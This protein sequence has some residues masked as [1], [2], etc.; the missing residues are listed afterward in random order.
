[1]I[2]DLL[3]EGGSGGHMIHPFN[4]PSVN[5]G[6]DLIEFFEK[7]AQFV[8]RKPKEGE[9]IRASKSSSIKFDGVNASIKLIDGPGGK[10]FALDRGSLG[11]LDISGVTA[12]KLTQR[13]AEGH[14]MIKVGKI[15]LDIFNRALPSIEN[16]LKQLGVYDDSTKFLNAEFVWKKTN[17]VQYPED[18]IAIHGVNQYYEKTHSRN[19]NYRPGLTRPTGDDGKPVKLTSTEVDYDEDALESLKEKTKPIAERYG[20]NLYTVVPTFARGDLGEIDFGPALSTDVTIRFE[21]KA[22]TKPLQDWLSQA[23]NPRNK[24]V[25][26]SDGRKTTALSKFVYQ[27]LLGGASLAE[28]LVDPDD[29]QLAIDGAILYFATQLLGS[30][31]LN[32]L[33]SPLGDLTGTETNHEGIVLRDSELFGPRP[34]KI[35]GE[36]ISSG[37]DSPFRKKEPEQVSTINEEEQEFEDT[38]EGGDEEVEPLAKDN[39]NVM[40]TVAVFPGKFKPPQEGHME[41]VRR[42]LDKVDYVYVMISPLPRKV[43]DKDIG[44]L[45]SKKVWDLYIENENLEGKVFAIKSPFNS[46]VQASYAVMDGE[47]PEFVPRKGD[48]I[49]PVASDKLDAPTRNRPGRPDYLRFAKYHE[50]NPKIA[51]VIPANIED[52]YIEAVSDEGGSLNATDFRNALAEGAP[53]DRFIPFGINPDDVRMK[54]GF[55]P[56]ENNVLPGEGQPLGYVANKLT[57]AIFNIIGDELLESNY[58]PI[59]KKRMRSALNFTKLGRKDLVK[60]GAPFTNNI[61]VGTSNAFLAKE[62]KEKEE[63][64]EEVS[65]MAGG[66]V[67][68]AA[69]KSPFI[70]FDE[71][72]NEKTT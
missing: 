49:V 41:A 2:E 45:E 44:Y 25:T 68:G 30:V 28:L 71:E 8:M 40:R 11:P 12:E 52:Y 5:T 31:V 48:L 58:Q 1:M 46:P 47:I 24:S 32:S 38:D 37:A 70:N 15:M 29:G 63:E 66:S 39:P 72:E 33:S 60:H 56:A 67:E 14:G 53:I 4:L 6:N 57:E 34:V 54:L 61:K 27:S 22:V 43:N 42:I 19:G 17:V 50:Y 3:S 26:L 59:A 13:F 36:F 55:E 69:T 23:R 21:E 35:T 16:E 20:F 10:E 9:K 64:L 18:F 65:S 7:A 51:G 62:E